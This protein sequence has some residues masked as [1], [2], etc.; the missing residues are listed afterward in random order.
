MGLRGEFAGA[1]SGKHSLLFA[2]EIFLGGIL[3]AALLASRS[4]RT[5]PPVLFLGALLATAGVIFNRV[6]VVLLAMTLKGSMP[7][8]APA[9]YYPTAFEWG[10][11]VGLIAATIFLFELGARLMPILPKEEAA[12]EVLIT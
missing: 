1:F 5:R 2:A 3:P 10:V 6:N 11:S 9:T 12:Q 4:L 8:I 7:Q